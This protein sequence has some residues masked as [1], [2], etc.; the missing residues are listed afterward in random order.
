MDQ[1]PQT[2]IATLIFCGG[3]TRTHGVESQVL[4]QLVVDWKNALKQNT[5]AVKSYRVSNVG[6]AQAGDLLLDPGQ[7]AAIHVFDDR[8]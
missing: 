1:D 4:E 8:R 7:I 5:R 3:E 2:R 6:Y